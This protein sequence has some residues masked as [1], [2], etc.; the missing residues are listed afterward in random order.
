MKTGVCGADLEKGDVRQRK[1]E[2]MEWDEKLQ[3]I[4]SCIENNLHCE[5]EPIDQKEIAE[6]AGCSFAFFQKV[7]SYMNGISLSEYI[8]LRK[9]TFAGYDL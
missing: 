2:G 5:K 4:I 9:L 1:R 6:I 7:F 3:K 8:R